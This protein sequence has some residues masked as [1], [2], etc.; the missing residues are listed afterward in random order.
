MVTRFRLSLTGSALG[1]V[2]ACGGSTDANPSG[3]AS[4]EGGGA[5][6]TGGAGGGSGLAGTGGGSGG[7][8]NA[9]PV[10]CPGANP[11]GCTHASCSGNYTTC[12]T[13]KT[14]APSTCTVQ[15]T[16]VRTRQHA[17]A[18]DVPVAALPRCLTRSRLRLRTSG[19][20]ATHVP[21]TVRAVPGVRPSIRCSSGCTAR[22]V[23]PVPS[24]GASRARAP[25]TCAPR[26]GAPGTRA[27][28]TRAL[29]IRRSPRIAVTLRGT[30]V[31]PIGA[32]A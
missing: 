26:A 1:F 9:P 4:V 5:G 30:R 32:T 27:P 6:G 2:A 31:R 25:G 20:V 12:D 8:G 10:S 11:A 18:F 14:C 23:L 24:A 21:V 22:G 15:T 16:S 3:D 29:P 28:G 7:S 19:A 13:S 17:L